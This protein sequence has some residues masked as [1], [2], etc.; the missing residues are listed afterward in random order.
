MHPD[1][2]LRLVCSPALFGIEPDVS[3]VFLERQD[4]QLDKADHRPGH[5]VD[6]RQWDNLVD[7]TGTKRE[8]TYLYVQ[9]LMPIS[10]R[11]FE[12][13]NLYNGLINSGALSKFRINSNDG[14][15]RLV[16]SSRFLLRLHYF[17]LCFILGRL[18]TYNLLEQ[19]RNDTLKA[20]PA[21]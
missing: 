9:K 21:F 10:Q 14:S 11:F 15:S 5:E 1:I 2:E 17:Y 8:L 12:G 4:C 6:P 16:P 3:Q 18:R 7:R 20:Y 19:R 13:K